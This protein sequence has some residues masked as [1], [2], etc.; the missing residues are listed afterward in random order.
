MAL[1]TAAEYKT[2]R[3]ISGTAYDT[4][5]GE[6]ID[7]ASARVREYCG[8]NL[9]N[10]F[11]SAARTEVYDGTGTDMLQL[12]EWPEITITS[13]KFLSSVASGAAV[14]GETLDASGYYADER[15]RLYRTNGVGWAW[16]HDGTT[17]DEWPEGNRNIQVVYTGGFSTVPDNLKEAVMILVDAWF[18][19]TQRDAVGLNQEA[20][21]VDNRQY[22]AAM[23]VTN[24]VATLLAPW[25][26]PYA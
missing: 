25:R 24:R 17:R 20:R 4:R 2:S 13:V 1:V 8:R 19:S 22:A 21:G 12:R 9:T 7:V 11:E 10:G 14:Y 15:G 16:T 3:G 18:Q 5:I 23:E 26:R 6:A